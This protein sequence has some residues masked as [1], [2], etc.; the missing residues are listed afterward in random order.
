MSSS[1]ATTVAFLIRASRGVE[2]ISA[3][4]SSDNDRQRSIA[5]EAGDAGPCSDDGCAA[6]SAFEID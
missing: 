6:Q 5:A 1:T 3:R 2:R 4:A